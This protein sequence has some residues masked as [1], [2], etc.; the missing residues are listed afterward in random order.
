M[1][2]GVISLWKLIIV[3]LI[4]V[5]IFG[6]KRIKTLVTGFGGAA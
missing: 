5:L 3:L 2:L 1:G 6:T 4:F